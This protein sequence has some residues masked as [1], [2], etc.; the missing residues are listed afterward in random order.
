MF[1]S[2]NLAGP[3]DVFLLTLSIPLMNP[4]QSPSGCSSGE[5][6]EKHAHGIAVATKDVD[7]GAAVVAGMSGDLDPDDAARVRRKIDRCI[8]PM[9]CTLYWIQFMDKNT[10]GSSAILGIQK[11]THLSTNQYN[12]LGTVFYLSYLLFEYPQNL[13]L[14]RFPVG[15]WMSINIFVW[16]IALACHAACTDF[17]GLFVARF[18]LGICEGSITA[19]FMIVS[20]MFYTRSEQTSRIGYWFLMNGTAQ[21]ISGFISFGSLHITTPGF[22]PWQWLV[23]ITGIITLITAVVYW[24]VNRELF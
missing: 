17:A 2:F 14:Q 21:I 19:G 10:L 24:C 1:L 9:M 13:A 3:S 11:D 18:V 16:G 23:I 15:R 5:E 12:W 4:L 22:A 7:T 8:L 6:V 20:S